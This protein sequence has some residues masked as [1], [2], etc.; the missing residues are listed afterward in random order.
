MLYIPERGNALCPVLNK[1]K[2]V[3]HV[4]N[5]IIVELRRARSPIDV[6]QLN[7]IFIGRIAV[8]RVKSGMQLKI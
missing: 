5:A 3:E 4:L 7:T 1:T 6:D 8:S 2:H